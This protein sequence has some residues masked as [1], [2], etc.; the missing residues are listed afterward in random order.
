M[1]EGRRASGKEDNRTQ[2]KDMEGRNQTLEK[3]NRICLISE[4]VH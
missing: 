3:A 1:S 2:E 4:E